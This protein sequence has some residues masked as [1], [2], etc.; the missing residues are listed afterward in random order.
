MAS[1]QI[2]QYRFTGSGCT[3]SL[4]AT[5]DVAEVSSSFSSDGS[6]GAQSGSFIDISLT[7][8]ESFSKGEDYYLYLEIPQD[9]N[10]DMDFS[11]KLVKT[12]NN[13]ETNY[14][15][16]KSISV[17]RGGTGQYNHDVCLYKGVD[18]SILVNFP[19]AYSNYNSMIKKKSVKNKIYLDNNT[20]NYYIGLGASGSNGYQLAQDSASGLVTVNASVLSETWH[21]EQGKNKGVFE[22]CFRPVEDGFS[23][24]LLQMTRTAEDYSISRSDGSFGRKIDK[25]NLIYRLYQL[26]NKVDDMHKNGSLSRIGVWG[27]AG[28]MMAINGEEIRIGPSGYYELDTVEVTSLGVVA[29]SEVVNKDGV[30]DDTFNPF[31]NNWTCDYEYKVTDDTKGSE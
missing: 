29:P 24:I 18:D 28:M 3:T 13:S 30:K 16:L 20:G 10:Y 19:V 11:I 5:T 26:S 31:V 12:V 9:L 2:G 6:S 4:T 17:L 7:P 1:Y 14:Q 27:H 23:K 22:L 25:D 15:F 8:Q 21:E